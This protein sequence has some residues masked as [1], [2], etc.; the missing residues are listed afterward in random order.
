M[1]KEMAETANEGKQF[2][3]ELKYFKNEIYLLLEK[4]KNCKCILVYE[5]FMP[6]GMHRANLAEIVNFLICTFIMC[7]IDYS[8][9][10]YKPVTASA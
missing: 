6:R 1:F 10:G 4:Y 7:T 9:V 2:V 5:R 8:F 3:K